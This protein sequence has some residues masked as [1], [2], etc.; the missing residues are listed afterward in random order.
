MHGTVA[1]RAVRL[2]LDAGS[3][4]AHEAGA[5]LSRTLSPGTDAPAGAAWLDAFLAGDAVLLLHDDRLLGVIDDWVGR[6]GGEVFDD[7]LPLLRRTFSAFS[8]AERR[9]IGDK[10]RRLDATASAPPHGTT[11]EG[12]IDVERA[13]RAVPL[14][15]LILGF[16]R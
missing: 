11:L 10:V 5:R 9:M 12:S 14:L 1:G 16:D 3:V 8:T 13:R 7:L 2:L 15:R 4:D 6:V